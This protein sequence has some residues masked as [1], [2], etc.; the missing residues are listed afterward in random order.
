MPTL[1]VQQGFWSVPIDSVGLAWPNGSSSSPSGAC[2]GF[3]G[4]SSSSGSS[5]QPGCIGLLDSGTSAIIG[6]IDQVAALNA[7]L[8]GVPS[9]QQVPFDCGKA[10]AAV[11]GETAQALSTDD[12][13]AAANQV[14]T[15][16][17]AAV[18]LV[19]GLEVECCHSNV[20]ASIQL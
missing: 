4:S 12:P 1:A 19:V 15:L 10:V 13:D 2:A 6:S 9:I 18:A 16:S 11:L 7:A 14:R 20:L 5:E 3:A 17:T 8:G